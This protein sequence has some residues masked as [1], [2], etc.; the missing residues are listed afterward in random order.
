M[1]EDMKKYDQWLHSKKKRRYVDIFDTNLQILFPKVEHGKSERINPDDRSRIN[2][3]KSFLIR[4]QKQDLEIYYKD[5]LHLMSIP[6]NGVKFYIIDSNK[7]LDDFN[8]AFN[9]FKKSKKIKSEKHSNINTN[10]ENEITTKPIYKKSIQD[11]KNPNEKVL[12]ESKNKEEI[13][14]YSN[15]SPINVGTPLKNYGE[16][17]SQKRFDAK[18]NVKT[19]KVIYSKNRSNELVSYLKNLYKNRCQ[20]CN[21]RIEIGLNENYSEVHHI[22]PLNKHDGPDIIENMIVLCPNHHVMFDYGAITIDLNSQTVQHFKPSNPINKTKFTL[23]H[24]IN[25]QFL[26]YHNHFIYQST[27]SKEISSSIPSTNSKQIFDN[28]EQLNDSVKP[29]K[30]FASYGD[31]VTFFDYLLNDFETI[32]LETFHNQHLMNNMQLM[33][34]NKKIGEPFT[35]NNSNFIVIN[36]INN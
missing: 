3:I 17:I 27:C 18:P 35:F 28:Q 16:F 21:E 14:S 11:L 6:H 25:K 10:Q 5:F 23:K 15:P 2:K 20:L 9:K 12:P 8:V 31:T 22:Q 34:L 29:F 4:I 13:V 19:S 36:I 24:T 26:D 7:T 33:L 30:L 1:G 32:T